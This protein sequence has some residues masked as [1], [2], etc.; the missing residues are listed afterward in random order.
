MLKGEV[1]SVGYGESNANMDVECLIHILM[2]LPMSNIC[3]A[4]VR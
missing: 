3:V 4:C 2:F 1:W